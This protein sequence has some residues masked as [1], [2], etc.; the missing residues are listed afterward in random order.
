M[1]VLLTT[2]RFTDA[3]QDARRATMPLP[4]ATQDTAELIRSALQGIERLFRHGSRYKKAGVILTELVPAP[5]IQ[6]HLF[7]RRDRERSQR[8]IAAID[9]INT[10]WGSGTI[11]SAAVGLQ[12]RW[13]MRCVRRSPRSTTRWDELVVARC[14]PEEMRGMKRRDACEQRS[15]R[16]SRE[17]MRAE[18][19]RVRS[20]L[21]DCGTPPQ[22]AQSGP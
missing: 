18:N 13:R 12:P 15:Y 21:R 2:H 8:R 19:E 5:Q 4:V 16:W 17:G 7:D 3:P 10:R 6:T 20:L 14:D 1:T 9:A 22:E 11:G